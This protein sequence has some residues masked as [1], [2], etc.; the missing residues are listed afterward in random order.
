MTTDEPDEQLESLSPADEARIR[1]LLSDARETGPMPV[2]VAARLEEA[3]V[4][5]A[6]ERARALDSGYGGNVRPLVRTRRH[7]VVAVL[8]AAAAVAVLGLGIGSFFVSTDDDSA[9]DSTSADRMVDRGAES[10]GDE[11]AAEAD[12]SAK[13]DGEAPRLDPGEDS[14]FVSTVAPYAV[15]SRHLGPDLTRI[16]EQLLPDPAADLYADRLTAAPD[17]FEC[18]I[19]PVDGAVLVGVTYDGAPAYVAFQ[20][21]M[22]ASQV[23]D[24][25]QC[26]TG[27]VL[28]STTLPVPR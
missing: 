15:H 16:R 27:D 10:P 7:R 22:G 13:T 23:V 3:I 14:G 6:A 26:R 28:R 1:G 18:A 2:A 24:V 12:A 4:D 11:P 19:T 8:G 17:G 21:P 20:R 5:A 25:L 9:H